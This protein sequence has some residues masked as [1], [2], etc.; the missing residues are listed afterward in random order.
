MQISNKPEALR[1]EEIL[2][3]DEAPASPAAVSANREQV[4]QKSSARVSTQHAAATSERAAE[5]ESLALPED[6]IDDSD[7]ESCTTLTL[8][9]VGEQSRYT[10]CQQDDMIQIHHPGCSQPYRVSVAELA[11]DRQA[12]RLAV[13]IDGQRQQLRCDPVTDSWFIAPP[14][15]AN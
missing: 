11:A 4:L 13:M 8:I 15:A 7:P 3:A 9:D 10:V 14:A 5:E 12:G 2:M 6:R 1:S